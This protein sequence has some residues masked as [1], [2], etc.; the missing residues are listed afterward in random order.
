MPMAALAAVSMGMSAMSAW[1]TYQQ[2]QEQRNQSI[3]QAEALQVQGQQAQISAGQ[4]IGEDDY[5][6][7]HIIA[8]MQSLAAA[9]G[10]DET[11]GS[12]AMAATTSAEEAKLND[13]YTKFAGQVQKSD[14]DYEGTLAK[15]SGQEKAQA[16]TVGAVTGL[17]SGSID[18]ATLGGAG[19]PGG[20]GNTGFLKGTWSSP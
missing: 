9:S 20:F 16:G 19:S 7:G 5:K 13:M 1:Q 6:A 17:I 12:T 8:R 3:R 15:I 10:V 4:K 14:L 2:G 11:S 18:A